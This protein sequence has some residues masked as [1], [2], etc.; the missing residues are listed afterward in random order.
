MPRKKQRIRLIHWNAA[1]A[2]EKA[3]VLKDAGYRVEHE[4]P[5]QATFNQ[6]RNDPPDAVV[7]DLSRIPSHGRDTGIFLR[8]TKATRHVPIVFVEGD[9]AKVERVKQKLPDAVYTTWRRI[10][11]ALNRAIANPPTEPV[12]LE[13]VMAGYAG[14]PLVKKLGIKQ[15]S[16]VTLVGAP[17][18]FEQTLGKLPEGVKFR[19]RAGGRPDLAIWF[20][21]SRKELESRVVRMGEMAGKDGLWIAWPKKS[22]GVASDLTQAIVR[23]VGLASGLVDYKICAIDTTWS[24][25]RFAQRKPTRKR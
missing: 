6:I 22:S 11:G 1:E 3:A 14:T 13:S 16:V 4:V 25:L 7:I 18:D 21:K 20:T 19:R 5:E 23:K 12:A 17:T 10:R 9:A 15:G 8:S 2:K 24:G